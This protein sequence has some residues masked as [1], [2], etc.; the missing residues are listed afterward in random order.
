[1]QQTSESLQAL[2]LVGA[3]VTINSTTATLSK[4]TGS[5]ATWSFSSPSPATG[6]V[7]ITSSTGQVAF[8][9]TISL[10][11]GNQN[12]TWN[13]QGN[14]GVT[15]PDGNYTMS[16]TATGANGQPVT[17]T[18]QVQGTISSVN[19]SQNPPTITVNGQSYPISAIQSINSGGG[20]S[21]NGLARLLH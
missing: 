14:N 15:W 13:G 7:T 8:T 18:T 16:I 10:S 5:P 17:V 21:S 19:I 9:G 1:M 2:Q 11:A 3:N 4:A 12:Y 6:T 20:S